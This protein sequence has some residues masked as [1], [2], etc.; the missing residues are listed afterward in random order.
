MFL[1]EVFTDGAGIIEASDFHTGKNKE[2]TALFSQLYNH[3]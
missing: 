2:I 1:H 3:K